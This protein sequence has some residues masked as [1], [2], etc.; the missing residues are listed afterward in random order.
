MMDGNALNLWKGTIILLT[1]NRTVINDDICNNSKYT[2][3]AQT[4]INIY[5][6]Y[7]I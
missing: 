5:N 3:I 2:N 1:T 4:N 6:H 7:H